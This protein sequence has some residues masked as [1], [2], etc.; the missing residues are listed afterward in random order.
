MRAKTRE[1]KERKARADTV[2]LAAAIAIGK[3]T[4]KSEETETKTT[5]R[6][7]VSDVRALMTDYVVR[8]SVHSKDLEGRPIIR[9]PP[10]IDIIVPV[11]LRKD[12]LAVQNILVDRL[13]EE[14]HKLTTGGLE[15]FYL[16]IRK[17]LLHKCLADVDEHRF[18]RDKDQRPYT[19]Y[20]SSKLDALLELLKYHLGQTC[21]PP[22]QVHPTIAPPAADPEDWL[23]LPDASIDKI[24]VYLAFP[25]SNWLVRKALEHSGVKYMEINSDK[26]P[27]QRAETLQAF[28]LSEDVQV[29]LMSNVGTVGLNI[30]FA[31]IVIVVD[32]LWSA[33]EMEQLIGRVWRHPQ[34]KRVLIYSLIAV[35]TSDVFLNTISRDKGTMQSGFMNTDTQLSK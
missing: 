15:A 3:R 1:T 22:A 23:R 11:E 20:P 34:S 12:E 17:A 29:L 14:R 2:Q 10:W 16:G 28:R 8:R 21:A 35:G 33:Q 13:K 24:I 18:P 31:N 9:L 19:D 32:N 25:S 30:A 27:K 5:I 6:A 4:S 26:T 7:W